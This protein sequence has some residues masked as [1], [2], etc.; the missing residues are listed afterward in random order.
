MNQYDSNFAESG[1]TAHSAIDRA[2]EALTSEGKYAAD[3]TTKNIHALADDAKALAM[4]AAGV[5]G[6]QW[7]RL[8]SGFDDGVEEARAYVIDQPMKSV[9][10]SAV[11]GAVFMAF[12]SA[13]S[14]GRR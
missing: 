10:I 7:G 4:N 6:E 8:K 14:R 12:L 9:M 5:A 1:S 3:A 2:S 13:M 11:G